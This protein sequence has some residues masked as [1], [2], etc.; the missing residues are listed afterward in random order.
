MDLRLRAH[1]NTGCIP[2]RVDIDER[3]KVVEDKQRVGDWELDT[4]IGR[5]HN[6]AIVSMV[7]R[8]SK[9]TKLVLVPNKTAD[10]VWTLANFSRSSKS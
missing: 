4:I 5:N 1:L 3:P 9:F 2:E 6:G 10:I 7:D 8:A